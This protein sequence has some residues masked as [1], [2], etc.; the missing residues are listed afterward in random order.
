[1]DAAT[2]AELDALRRRAYGPEPDLD[3]DA[4]ARLEELED[5]LFEERTARTE[6]AREEAAESIEPT[7]EP[8]DEPEAVAEASA[9]DAPP[10][11]PRRGG[12]VLTTVGA[13]AVLAI[14]ALMVPRLGSHE[15]PAA[16]PTSVY[17]QAR[18][19]YSLV[20]DP[21]TETI[22]RVPLDGSFGNYV[23]V[24]AA[25]G[26]PDFPTSGNVEWAMP[27]GEYYGWDL[28]IAGAAGALQREHCI[29]IEREDWTRA[30][31]VPATLRTQSALLVSVPFALVEPDE[32]PTPMVEGERIGF[33]W[34]EDTEVTVL[35]GPEY[36]QR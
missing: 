25:G 17:I 10:A 3:D 26:V 30:R 8:I 29:L 33:W 36:Q 14:V 28:W 23:D 1:M 9:D 6:G 18:E 12:L 24:P 4:L 5:V 7:A 15:E 22:L 11:H 20:R 16:A 2:R 27:L 13:L 19:A 31:C 35:L 34:G 21:E 32:R